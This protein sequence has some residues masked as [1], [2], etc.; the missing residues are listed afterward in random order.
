MAI[1]S[2]NRD[3]SVESKVNKKL[4]LFEKN[5][6]KAFSKIKSEFDDH[7]DSINQNTNEIQQNYEYLCKLDMKIEKLSERID[8]MSLFLKQLVKMNNTNETMSLT[9]NEKKVFLALYNSESKPLS[10]NE[11]SQQTGIEEHLVMHYIENLLMKRIPLIKIQK[12]NAS[13]FSLDS[14]FKELQAKK[15][16]LNITQT[17]KKSIIS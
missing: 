9:E 8:E 12:N 1:I 16:I 10:Y 14:T 7:L 15:N 11:I 3:T 2:F 4:Y 13:Y 17:M 5:I 6:K